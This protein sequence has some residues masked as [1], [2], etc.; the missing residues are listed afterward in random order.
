MQMRAARQPGERR[1]CCA[2]FYIVLAWVSIGLGIISGAPSAARLMAGPS[3]DQQLTPDKRSGAWRD[4]LA[5]TVLILGAMSV[6]V[7]ELRSSELWQRTELGLAIVLILSTLTSWSG[8]ARAAACSGKR[9][10]PA[11]LASARP[12]SGPAALSFRCP[13]RAPVPGR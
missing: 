13:G 6:L 7:T 11:G 9:R 5:S 10:A 4:V 12:P 8:S 1:E 3:A 2:V